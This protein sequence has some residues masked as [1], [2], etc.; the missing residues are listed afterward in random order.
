M[1]DEVNEA[2]RKVRG[3]GDVDIAPDFGEPGREE[4][5]KFER[6]GVREVGECNEPEPC[7]VSPEPPDVDDSLRRNST[8]RWEKD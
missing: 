4:R 1:A 5:E 6:V 3:P 7:D 8:Q 2:S